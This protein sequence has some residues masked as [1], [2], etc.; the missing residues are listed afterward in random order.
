MKETET[1]SEAVQLNDEKSFDAVFRTWYTPLVR[2]ALSFTEGDQDEAEELVQNAFAKLWTQR[3][4]LEFHHSVK[5]Y[6][7]RM[8]HNQALN[9]IR[10]QRI[11]QRFAQHHARQMAQEYESPKENPELMGRIRQVLNSLPEQC[12]HVFELSRFEEL[13]YREIADQLGISIKTVESHMGKALR[14][15][16]NEL[17]EYLALWFYL[18]HFILF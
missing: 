13:K 1:S 16:R 9:R 12:R 15:M 18:V 14:I 11:Q 6:L 4:Q 5:A 2:Y 8:V 10:S 17:S 7:Y 3:Q